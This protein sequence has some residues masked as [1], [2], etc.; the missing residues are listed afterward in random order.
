MITNNKP[1]IFISILLVL[2]ILAS[3]L[4]SLII[5][6]E[7]NKPITYEYQIVSPLDFTFESSMNS[8]GESGWQATDCRRARDSVTDKMSYECIMIRKKQ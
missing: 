6:T 2:N 5:K 1:V 7:I 4:Q 8:E 3:L